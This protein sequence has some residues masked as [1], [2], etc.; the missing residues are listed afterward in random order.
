MKEAEAIHDR[1]GYVHF[2]A[3]GEAAPLDGKMF[4]L[5]QKMGAQAVPTLVAASLLAKK[6]VA[7]VRFV[8]LDIRVA[9]HGNFG[10]TW[11]EAKENAH[12]FVA[13]AEELNLSASPALTNGGFP[14]QPYL[15]RAESLLA[16]FKLFEGSADLWLTE[17]SE[18][19]RS[20]ALCCA[21]LKL[22]AAISKTTPSA[23]YSAFEANVR[24]QS[25]SLDAFAKS[26]ETVGKGHVF[27]ISAHQSGFAT[28]MLRE[29]RDL[30]V[31]L[32]KRTRTNAQFPDPAGLILLCRPG[33][34]VERKTPM[35]TVR[36][37]LKDG[38]SVLKE[39]ASMIY[40][41]PAIVA[42]HFESVL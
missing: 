14:Y 18:L 32:Q 8:G 41:T 28:F 34:W 9:A 42:P 33:E 38:N 2:L 1:A 35:A 3:E 16:L 26:A 13:V 40:T 36:L 31:G 22:R 7:R 39:I 37:S 12:F 21:P 30:L 27:Q 19:C 5:R 11:S 24:A 23:L 10:T 4:R 20:L 25:G 6:L 17:H 15:G 29:L